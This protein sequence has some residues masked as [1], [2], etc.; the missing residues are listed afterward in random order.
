[1]DDACIVR[2]DPEGAQD[3]TLDADGY[4]NPPNPDDLTLYNASTQG[5]DG[6][7]L[8]DQDA[9]GGKCKVKM[10]TQSEIARYAQDGG[11]IENKQFYTLGVPWDAPEFP[12]NAV[13]QIVSSRRDP[14]MVGQE[15]H[16]RAAASI[17]TFNVSRKYLCEVRVR[18]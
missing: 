9:T 18:A 5:L 13:A 4:L 3:E 12:I 14:L 15:L 8:A 6:R 1:M 10:A 11:V 7:S 17:G 2:Y 16:T